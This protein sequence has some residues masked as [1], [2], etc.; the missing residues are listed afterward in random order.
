[1]GDFFRKVA[2]DDTATL[3]R[4]RQL[5]P[6]LAAFEF[7]PP[8]SQTYFVT[9]KIAISACCRVKR[10][11]GVSIIPTVHEECASLGTGAARV[12]HKLLVDLL[13][14]SPSEI[15]DAFLSL[16]LNTPVLPHDASKHTDSKAKRSTERRD[17]HI[18]LETTVAAKM[19]DL[20]GND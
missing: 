20:L 4:H 6:T 11:T 5:V 10:T 16:V 19:A 18:L 13:E 15:R 12:A 1:M 9:A 17:V 7:R 14:E 2:E 8:P 3:T